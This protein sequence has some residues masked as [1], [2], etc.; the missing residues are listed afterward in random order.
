MNA[1]WEGVA[2]YSPS[3]RAN[4]LTLVRH[5]PVQQTPAGALCPYI[6]NEVL[7]QFGARWLRVAFYKLEAGKKI[8][9]HRDLVHDGFRR[10]TVRM[11]MPVITNQDVVMYVDRRPYHFAPGTAWYLDPTARHK[12]ENNSQEDRIHLMADFLFE[13]TLPDLL[14][15]A[16]QSGSAPVRLD[17]GALL[18][19]R[20]GQARLQPGSEAAPQA[21]GS[22]RN[23]R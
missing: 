23:E 9:E 2:L 6:C 19:D 15:D 5:P 10:V 17:V 1:G 21:P 4:N 12:V 14:E 13:G 7:P 8:G 18:H 22:M 11:H 3:G 20:A 16:H